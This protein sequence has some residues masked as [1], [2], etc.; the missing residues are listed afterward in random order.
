MRRNLTKVLLIVL[1]ISF[2]HLFSVY[3]ALSQESGFTAGGFQWGGSVELGYRLTDIDGSKD[4]YREIINLRDGLKLFD[5]SLQGNRVDENTKGLID[6]LRFNVSNVGDPYSSARLDIKKNKTYNLSITYKQYKYITLQDEPTLF[7]NNI[8][9]DSTIRTG[10]VLLSVFPKEDVKL[11]FG[12]NHTQRDGDAVAPRRD[13][14]LGMEQNL[15]EQYNEYFVSADFPIGG[16]DLHLK[17]SISDYTNRDRINAPKYENRD[18]LV[19]TYV[20][21]LRGHT[22]LSE[23][24]DFDAAY[25][26]AHSDGNSQLTT[27]PVTTVFPGSG[28]LD[29]NT[30]IIE[31]GL[32]YLLQKNLIFH[33]DYRFHTQ[34]QN[35]NANTDPFVNAPATSSSSYNLMAHTG[36]FQLEYIPVDN[37][38][39]RAGYRLQYQHVY[40]DNYFDAGIGNGNGGSSPSS[41]TN[42]VNG[43]VA[44]VNWKPVKVLSLF[45]EY[46]GANFSNPYT[47]ISPTSQNVARIKVKYDTPL[48]GLSFKG[49]FSWRRSINPD[50]NYGA[51]VKDYTFTAIYQPVPKVSFDASYTYE[52]V[53]DSKGIF[54]PVPFAFEHTVFNSNS[55]IWSGGLTLENIYQGLGGRIHGSYAKSLGENPQNYVDGLI[56][57]WYKNKLVTPILTLERSYLTDN[58]VHRDGFNAN[59]ITFSLRKDF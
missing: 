41:N 28:K 43:W 42:W 22:Q 50:Q 10:S 2:F 12:Y 19:R 49:N 58:V 7:T 1:C 32:S 51:D 47:W 35:G 31:T 29:F 57:L 44:S 53:R 40:G 27:L 16:W 5:F 18:E 17:Q 37:L 24:L 15:K 38:T 4:R 36:T 8:G 56:S 26:Y 55:S 30:H 45:G 39:L 13:F 48:K 25:I 3:S 6:S 34:D 20:T 54:N 9:F 14:P 11:N 59:L 33:A 21:T 52:D 23:R 46:E